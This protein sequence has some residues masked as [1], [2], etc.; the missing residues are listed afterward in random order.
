MTN[1]LAAALGMDPVELR[2]RNLAREGSM[3][4]MGSPFPPGVTIRE[5]TEA[6]A[7]QAGDEVVA[8]SGGSGHAQVGAGWHASICWT[9]SGSAVTLMSMR[10]AGCAGGS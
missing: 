3:Q 10:S 5:V 8:R 9:A 1:K 2:M 4:T 7:R 6:C